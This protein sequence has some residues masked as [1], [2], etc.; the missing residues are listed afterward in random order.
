VRRDDV[1]TL[2]VDGTQ[3]SAVAGLLECRIQTSAT[4]PKP[5]WDSTTPKPIDFYA[6]WATVPNNETFAN[7]YRAQWELFLRHI[8]DDAPFHWTLLEAAKGTQLAEKALDAARKRA[9]VDLPELK[10]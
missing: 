9:W 5:M 10:P 2:Q 8:A 7:P 6:D 4:T 1:F 3:G